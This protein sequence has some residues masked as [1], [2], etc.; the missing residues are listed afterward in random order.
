[1]LR[2]FTALLFIFAGLAGVFWWLGSPEPTEDL[3]AL[4]QAPRAHTESTALAEQDEGAVL[5]QPEVEVDA[6]DQRSEVIE[7]VV[8]EARPELVR[9]RVFGRVCDVNDVPLAGVRVWLNSV[10][11]RWIT[12]EQHPEP[13]PKYEWTTDATGSFEFDVP[14]PTSSWISLSI[15]PSD[16]HS[17]AGRDFGPAG[18][19]DEEPLRAG[20]NDLGTFVLDETGAFTGRVVDRG[21]APIA[22]ARARLDGAFPGGY[23]LSSKTGTDGTYRVGHVPKGR[24]AAEALAKGYLT[25]KVAVV[26]V[27]GGQVTPG[28][29]FV[30]DSAASISG[31]VVDAEGAPLAGA[32][33]WGWPS[34]SGQG[35]GSRSAAD[36]SFT[37]YLPQDEPYSMSAKLAGYETFES[38][39]GQDYPPGT[40]GLEIVLKRPDLATFV[41]RDAESGEAIERFG[42]ATH[43]VRNAD[44]R[45]TSSSAHDE[46]APLAEHP[47][48][49]AQ[50]QG[51][52]LYIYTIVAPG[53]GPRRGAV[54]FDDEGSRQQTIELAKDGA[55]SGRFVLAGEGLAHPSIVLSADRIPLRPGVTDDEDDIFSNDWGTDMDRFAGRRQQHRGEEDGR[56]RIEGLAQG[57]YELRFSASG[58]ARRVVERVQVESGKSTDLGDIE[59]FTSGEIR[60]T[61]LLP[62]GVPVSGLIIAT[63]D[64]HFADDERAQRTGSS[65]SFHFTGLSE[66]THYLWVEEKAGVLLSGKPTV[67]QLARSESKVL[68]LDLSERVPCELEVL[69]RIG[70]Q[71]ASGLRVQ[72]LPPKGRVREVGRTDSQGVALGYV[73]VRDD[74]KLRVLG[75]SGLRL[76]D[77]TLGRPMVANT[78]Q[79]VDVNFEAGSLSL[80]IVDGGAE[81][82]GRLQVLSVVPAEGG[83]PQIV[84]L[85]PKNWTEVSGELRSELGYIA[86]GRYTLSLQVG[87]RRV[88]GVA[89]VAAGQV[90]RCELKE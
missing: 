76:G 64:D 34:S 14:L 61:I 50:Q 31:R 18:G 83:R 81:S 33:L 24:Y 22:E 52:S 1:M 27:R 89:E 43:K 88:L 39:R 13:I 12:E 82:I 15:K 84:H 35:A 46:P 9:S 86:P 68:Q 48:G 58:V 75:Q 45:T 53:Y 28:I 87:P 62:A 77:R 29:D 30:L 36:G 74:S 42:L 90:V 44:G 21:G 72:A 54:S 40:E 70:G 59:A 20:D 80:A 66:G 32:K 60:G 3:E 57:T 85:R 8:A 65:G 49:V 5:G 73:E 51:S 41:V 63:G 69:V 55:I 26:E 6:V 25:G 10:G 79:S 19:R 7:P 47:G 16:F 2:I 38:K 71:P 17:R 78:R 23:S 37:V 56:F 11:E 67:V 4:S